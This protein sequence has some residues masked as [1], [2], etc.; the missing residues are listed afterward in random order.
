MSEPGLWLKRAKSAASVFAPALASSLSCRAR[1]LDSISFAYGTG[2][3]RIKV[4]STTGHSAFF[5]SKLS[6]V[7]DL[8]VLT[9]RR[10]LLGCS[11][12]QDSRH[13]R[14]QTGILLRDEA[15]R[16]NGFNTWSTRVIGSSVPVPNIHQIDTKIYHKK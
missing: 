2:T 11:V 4:A 1:L 14:G 10:Q 3:D 15:W 13:R 8:I 7:G 16:R 12:G 6:K 9:N 5:L